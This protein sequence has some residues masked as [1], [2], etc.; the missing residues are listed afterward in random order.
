MQTATQILERFR[1]ADADRVAWGHL[2]EGWINGQVARPES[3]DDLKEQCQARGIA[4]SVPDYVESIA[5]MQRDKSV[6]TIRLPA[7]ELVEAGEANLLEREV[8][9]PL[10]SFYEQFFCS[11][12]ANTAL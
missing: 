5:F 2:V 6:L 11:P 12:T 9:Y 3:V 7:R 10:P 4:I 8:G 1:V